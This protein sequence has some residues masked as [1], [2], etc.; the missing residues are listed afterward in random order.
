MKRHVGWVVLDAVATRSTHA[1]KQL[2]GTK[3]RPGRVG[4]PG[5][6]DSRNHPPYVLAAALACFL[7]AQAGCTLLP[8]DGLSLDRAQPEPATGGGVDSDGSVLGRTDGAALS[9][10][11]LL[12]EVADLRAEKKAASAR[13]LVQRYPDVAWELL[14]GAPPAGA[15]ADAL[16]AVAA[17]H[18]AQCLPGAAEGWESLLADRARRPEPYRRY[19]ERRAEFLAAV[20]RGAPGQALA[21]ELVPPANS[22]LPHL[23]RL[24]AMQLTAEALLADNRPAEAA[25]TYHRAVEAAAGKYPYYEAHLRLQ[26]SDPLRRAGRLDDAD[27]AWLA[28]VGGAGEGLRAEVGVF[29]PGFWQRAAYHRPVDQPWPAELTAL[30]AELCRRYGLLYD[31]A[32][33]TPAPGARQPAEERV[34]WACVGHW[35]LERGEP[36]AA[37]VALKRAHTLAPSPR[38]RRQLELAQAGALMAMEQSNAAAAILIGL[39][40]GAD[41]PV[42][43]QAMTMLGTLRL[44]GGNTQQGFTFL[45]RALEEGDPI[46][47]PGRAGAEADLGLAYLLMGD[48]ASGL[49][50]LRRAQARFEADG[51]DDLLLRSLENER[52]YM[53]QTRN[54]SEARAVRKRIERLEADGQPVRTAG[55]FGGLPSIGRADHKADTE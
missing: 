12:A 38:D 40:D 13:R 52:S 16:R 5:C 31:D 29:D 35:R 47:W 37:L 2:L 4:E 45:R 17:A 49:K 9:P 46:D 55:W 19:A 24:D 39:S 22:P 18:D 23:L 44:E 51:D 48:E 14:R 50:W 33:P 26:L 6:L 41:E 28:A 30:L 27:A 32:S 34:V 3:T 21:A 15:D 7:L 8:Q 43:R 42:A 53:E 10:E 1:V 20:R 54:R 25:K 36:E 11:Q